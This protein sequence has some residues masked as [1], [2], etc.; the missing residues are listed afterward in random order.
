[1]SPMVRLAKDPTAP[2]GLREAL[3]RAAT[4]TAP[5]GTLNRVLGAAGAGIVAG[6]A[7]TSGLAH[8][9]RGAPRWAAMSLAVKGVSVLAIFS[10]GA[11]AGGYAVHAH[12]A[13]VFRAAGRAAIAHRGPEAAGPAERLPRAGDP[14]APEVQA[15]VQAPQT[16]PT[17]TVAPAVRPALVPSSI[18]TA[19]P[20]VPPPAEAAPRRA[21]QAALLASA[22]ATS[23]MPIASSPSTAAE[24]PAV[25][26]T[27]SAVAVPSPPSSARAELESLRAIG[28]A[29]EER[30]P[31]DALAAID[32]HWT[33]YPSSPFDQELL[34]LEAEARWARHEPSVCSLLRA[35]GARYP[36]SLLRPRAEALATEARCLGGAPT[37]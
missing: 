3:D 7:V 29:V 1:M 12:D 10:A 25:A 4:E 30:R 27:E 20:S 31:L 21:A 6:G 24:T 11:A 5:S 26:P 19:A 22:R 34:F 15:T 8:A 35:F 14:V 37:R 28:S 32:A 17:D 16:P 13:A 18:S 9:S 2:P 33:R 23:E 36:R